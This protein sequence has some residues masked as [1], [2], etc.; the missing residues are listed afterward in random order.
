M[1]RHALAPGT[2]DPRG[3]QLE[4]CATQRNLSAEGRAQ[5]VQIGTAF[6]Q[7]GVTVEQVYSSQWCRC[8]ETAQLLDL[9]AVEP[10]PALN[11]FFAT[12]QRRD[13]QM[14]TLRA[15][16]ADLK[17]Q[18]VLVLV[19]HQVVITALTGVLPSSGEIVALRPLPN[20]EVEVIG[21][22]PSP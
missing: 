1:M 11:S 15:W 2:G 19:T 17:P 8:L 5:A 21:R 3:F 12:P 20:G 18:E 6:R 22:I 14:R 10:L 7:H 9:G 4:Q 13:P 16:L